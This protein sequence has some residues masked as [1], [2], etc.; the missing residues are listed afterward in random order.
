MTRVMKMTLAAVIAVALS[1]FA[2]TARAADAQVAKGQV[3]GKVVKADGTPAA[4]AQIRL[5]VRPQRGAKGTAK[6]GTAAPQPQATDGQGKRPAKGA[7]RE[8]VAQ[9]TTDANG[10]FTLSDVSAGEYVVAA[11]LKGAGNARQN[12]SVHGTSAA[13]VTLTLKERAAGK[14]G[15]QTAA[16]T[17]KSAHSQS[18]ARLSASTSKTGA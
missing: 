2:M 8:A 18:K 11:R 14:T 13:D 16:H 17:S 4:G 7:G 6:T 9:G 15:K 3:K 5:I 12:V 1:G 10:Q